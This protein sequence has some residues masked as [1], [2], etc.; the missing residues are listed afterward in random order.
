MC[1]DIDGRPSVTE[2][3]RLVAIDQAIRRHEVW[4]VDRGRHPRLCPSAD[5]DEVGSP[6]QEERDEENDRETA[7]EQEIDGRRDDRRALSQRTA[8]R[9]KS[10]GGVAGALRRFTT[11]APPLASKPCS[12]SA[13]EGS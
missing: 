13:V 2:D 4:H 6:A 11:N 8:V 9:Y 1:A 7:N 10:G 12:L 5:D 3:G